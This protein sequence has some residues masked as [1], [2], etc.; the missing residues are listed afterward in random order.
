M[1]N[2]TTATKRTTRSLFSRSAKRGHKFGI[3]SLS[4]C[5]RCGLIRQKRNGKIAYA[6]TMRGPWANE[7]TEE[8]KPN[9]LRAFKRFNPF[10]ADDQLK[11]LADVSENRVPVRW[12]TYDFETKSGAT[13]QTGWSRPFLCAAFDGRSWIGDSPD[14]STI[15]TFWNGSQGVRAPNSDVEHDKNELRKLVGP[16]LYDEI[17]EAID[18]HDRAYKADGVVTRFL[19]WFLV[20]ENCV[21][22][23]HVMCPDGVPRVEPVLATALNGGRFDMLHLLPFFVRNHDKYKVDVVHNGNRVQMIRV[24]SRTATNEKG[25]PLSWSIVDPGW[26]LSLRDIAGLV[27][28]RKLD[29]PFDLP[30]SAVDEWEQYCKHDVYVLAKGLKKLTSTIYEWGG[31]IDG[32]SFT[33]SSIALAILRRRH[34][35]E[36]IERCRHMPGC[37]DLCPVCDR[38]KCFGDCEGKEEQ[39]QKI[40]SWRVED[41]GRVIGIDCPGG[42]YGC[43]HSVIREGY[44][45]GRVQAYAKGLYENVCYIDLTSSYP[46]SMRGLLPTGRV[47]VRHGR[48]EFEEELADYNEAVAAGKDP[49]RLAFVQCSVF[50]PESAKF[51]P[52]PVLRDGAVEFPRGYLTGIWAIEELL[53]VLD[54]HVGGEIREVYR[55]FWYPA[56]R[57]FETGMDWLYAKKR[58]ATD[59]GQRTLGKLCCNAPYGKLG[60]IEDKRLFVLDPE[61][62]A[63]PEW[64]PVGAE[65][66]E[67]PWEESPVGTIPVHIDRNYIVPQCAATITARSRA[68]LLRGMWKI[69]DE[70]GTVLYSDTDSIIAAN[71]DIAKF[72]T[73]DPDIE[74][75][76]LPRPED[77]EVGTDRLGSWKDEY[78]TTP[79]LAALIIGRKCYALLS[80]SGKHPLKKKHKEECEKR[81]RVNADGSKCKACA[82]EMVV[83]KGLEFGL[84]T[85]GNIIK[86]ASGLKVKTA[87]RIP[88]FKGFISGVL[89][90]DGGSVDEYSVRWGS[91]AMFTHIAAA[92][93]GVGTKAKLRG[94]TRDALYVQ[95]QVEV[96]HIGPDETVIKG[97]LNPNIA[98][99]L[100]DEGHSCMKQEEIWRK[101]LAEHREQQ[102]LRD[103]EVSAARKALYRDAPRIDLSGPEAVV[104]SAVEA[105]RRMRREARAERKVG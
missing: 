19:E 99:L 25:K 52:L 24:T 76:P 62:K 87:P 17:T 35:V 88:Q 18:W 45:G 97:R 6:K 91:G 3:A 42:V 79:D 51:G 4:I 56:S 37:P 29:A 40:D 9:K 60:T 27:D 78:D 82:V 92:L 53:L 73:R 36:D 14:A 11:P 69:E 7:L 84:R 2:P 89:A 59:E 77:F 28:E 57:P 94:A 98:Q 81:G 105:R 21:T 15:K 10:T 86:I 34:L 80:K 68:R 64:L 85:L 8:C 26:P 55:S 13:E 96:M 71:F 61:K 16:V 70:G 104:M 31:V 103:L 38:L 33:V 47:K 65:S 101:E 58:F 95:R 43:L 39:D 49:P 41:D 22:G 23:V 50:V 83:W 20:P 63:H 75:K 74:S 66:F 90:N 102:R 93:E 72:V 1:T 100:N 46:A 5:S 48:E 32:R 67:D 12:V 54:K 44:V 30:E